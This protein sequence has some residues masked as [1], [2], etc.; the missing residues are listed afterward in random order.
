MLIL[1]EKFM[2]KNY[3]S[4]LNIVLKLWCF[5]SKTQPTNGFVSD[6]SQPK[7]FP[8]ESCKSHLFE[9]ESE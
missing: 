9:Y 3:P 1:F 7:K 5:V 6:L 4:E 8:I 2:S